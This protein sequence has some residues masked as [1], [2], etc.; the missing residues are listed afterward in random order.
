MLFGQLQV[1]EWK[2]YT[3]F[4]S[5]TSIKWTS[6]T[7]IYASTHG[8]ILIYD[9]STASFHFRN[10]D[11]GLDYSD[12][13]SMAITEDGI[14][15]LGGNSP[16]GTVQTYA[17]PFGLLKHIDHLNLDMIGKMLIDGNRLFAIYRSAFATGIIELSISEPENPHFEEIYHEF[18][19]G[20][21]HISDID[22]DDEF[23]YLTTD[24]G[25][26]RGRKSD[27]LNFQTS[28]EVVYAASDAE[29]LV[30]TGTDIYLFKAAGL[31]HHEND[32]WTQKV[33]MNISTV[34]DAKFE[35]ESPSITFITST[36]YR[37]F[38][39]NSQTIV[40]SFQT[41]PASRVTCFDS[42]SGKVVLGMKNRGLLF[43]DPMTGL[44]NGRA[45]NTLVCNRF[46]SITIGPHGE[47]IAHVNDP[48]GVEDSER[49]SGVMIMEDSTI[50]HVLTR[51]NT[52]GMSLDDPSIDTFTASRID[53]M[54]GASG[55]GGIAWSE[56]EK[57]VLGVNGVFPSNPQRN[58]GIITI[59]PGTMEYVIIDTVD[60]IL[61]GMHG[62][63]DDNSGLG[64]MSIHQIK[65]DAPGNIWAIN[66]YSENYNH[67]A[68]IRTPL[69]NWYHVTAPDEQSYLP[70]SIAF[71]SRNRAWIGFRNY[72][73]FSSGGIKVVNPRNTFADESDDIWYPVTFTREPPGTS[74]W[75]LTFDELGLLWILTSGGV[76]GYQVFDQSSSIQLS[77]VYPVDYFGYIPFRMGD[78]IISDKM[79]NKWITSQSDGVRVI[80]ESTSIWPDDTGFTTE[81]SP[82]LSN[83]VYDAVIDHD[84]GI[85]YFATE[86]GISSLRIYYDKSINSPKPELLVTPNP[87]I[88]AVGDPL[89]IDGCPPG[90]KVLILTLSGQ[91]VVELEA[92]YDGLASTQALWDG[93]NKNGMP[94]GSGIYLITAYL[95]DGASAVTK[96]A[97]IRQ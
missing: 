31:Y 51:L 38:S 49:L 55:T 83:I 6:S 29:Q 4:L 19:V 86:K 72:L 71:D 18:P 77:P 39:L 88:P 65:T 58:G 9:D 45:P 41:P 89:L 28:W 78:R 8:G 33:A 32:E 91:V 40:Y 46:H 21:S 75:D 26:F 61:D 66:A 42:Y 95:Q 1:G 11:D 43:L 69:G 52:D 7:K 97:L 54:S 90:A 96:V 76:Q 27:I 37:K 44:T 35:P 53:W 70:Q 80:T 2:S 15:Y 93:K 36:L 5:P 59:D 62:I 64:Y 24:G 87:F 20:I 48:Y 14:I 12:I 17:E 79:S 13:S 85:I 47:V 3:S 56:D 94:A 10:T 25:V 57:I 81:N 67:P 74:I 82:L 30:L 60:G 34:L 50:S 63:V 84:A 73:G 68:A 92:A 23:I 16:K 22:A